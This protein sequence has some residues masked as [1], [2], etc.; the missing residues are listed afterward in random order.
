MTILNVIGQC[1][2]L[3]GVRLFPKDQAPYYI[4]GMSVCAAFMLGVAL[5]ALILRVYLLRLNS[6]NQAVM[7]YEMVGMKEG[8][9][10]AAAEELMGTGRRKPNDSGFKFIL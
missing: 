3:V 4:K 2:P 5:L 10:D 9:A 1:G 8:D 6:K 7:E